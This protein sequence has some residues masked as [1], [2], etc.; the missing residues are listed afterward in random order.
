LSFHRLLYPRRLPLWPHRH[1][2]RH[3]LRHLG[4]CDQQCQGRR[5]RNSARKA[6]RACSA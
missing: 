3:H 6:S 4:R 2:P 5:V 1:S